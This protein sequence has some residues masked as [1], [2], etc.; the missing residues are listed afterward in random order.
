MNR[1]EVALNT[2]RMVVRFAEKLLANGFISVLGPW[3][4]DR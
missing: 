1:A 2:A 3:G 4:D